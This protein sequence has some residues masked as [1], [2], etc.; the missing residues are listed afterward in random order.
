MIV[1]IMTV[2][3]KE[4]RLFF[5][6]VLMMVVTYVEKPILLAVKVLVI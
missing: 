5:A 2:V 6:M 3:M 4:N 1:G